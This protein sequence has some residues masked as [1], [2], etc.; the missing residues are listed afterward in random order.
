[1]YGKNIRELN[2]YIRLTVY[3]KKILAFS[4]SGEQGQFWNRGV[5][6]SAS[7]QSFQFIIEGVTSNL[8]YTDIAI[9]DLSFTRGCVVKNE[10]LPVGTTPSPPHNPCNEN[11]FYCGTGD[12]CILKRKQCNWQIDCSTGADEADCGDCDFESGMCSWSDASEG[13]F[14]WQR[15]RAGD[16][17]AYD[18]PT[19]DHTYRNTTGHLVYIEGADGVAGKTAVMSSPQFLNSGGPYC[20]FHLWLYQKQSMNVHFALYY[21]DEETGT[22]SLLYNF[23]TAISNE[24]KWY[25]VIVP[26]AYVLPYFRFSLEATPI[27]DESAEW[28]DSKSVLALDDLE[29][30]NC[31]TDLHGLNC[32]FDD[33][34]FYHGFCMWRQA[35]GDQKDWKK[36]DVFPGDIPDHTTGRTFYIFVDFND[37]LAKKGD[38]AK[39]ESAVQSK[40]FSYDSVFTLWYYF[41]G[42]NVGVFRIIQNN[43]NLGENNTYFELKDSQEDRWML[44]EA[45]LDVND[46]FSMV[47]EAE[48]RDIGPGLLAVD[49]I[50][51]VARPVSPKCDFEVDY[52]QWSPGSL[53][54]TRWERAHGKD[55]LYGNPPVD[56]TTNS[57]MGYYAYLVRTGAS[58]DCGYL[59]SPVYDSVGSQC[60]RF[61]YHMLG[62][63][64]GQLKVLVRGEGSSPDFVPIWTH[65]NNTDEMWSLGMVTIVN[66]HNY[67]VGIEGMTGINSAAIIAIDDIEF[68][69]DSCPD[70]HECDFEYDLCDW[71]NTNNGDDTFDWERSSGYEGGGI[72][73]D[74]TID[75]E[76][77]HYMVA[78]LS[79]KKRGDNA[80]LFG[81]R[82]SSSL[83]CMTFWYSMQYIVNATLSVVLLDVG[84]GVP[85]LELPNSTLDYTWEEVTLTPVIM[86]NTFQ[87]MFEVYVEDDMTSSG[88]NAV[89][90]DDIAFTTN[91]K[92]PTLPPLATTSA[93]TH[94]PSL[95]DCDFEQDDS[96]TCG[97]RQD[98]ED[99]LDWQRHQGQ[100]PVEETGPDTDHTLLTHDGHYIYVSTINQ[101]ERTAKL[102]SPAINT[103]VSGACLSFWYHM[104][105]PSIGTLDIQ[106][107]STTSNISNSVWQRSHEQGTNW[108]QAKIYLDYQMF[109]RYLI[110]ETTP[111]CAGHGDIAVDDIAVDFRACNTGQLC[112]FEEGLCNFEQSLED[113]LDWEL[114]SAESS[115]EE[116]DRSPRKDHSRQTSSGQYLRLSGEGSAIIYSNK[117]NPNFKCAEFWLFS[118]G[119]LECEHVVLRVYRRIGEVT[120]SEAL[121]TVSGVFSHEWNLYRL[122]IDSTSYYSL[123][124][125]GKSYNESEIG[126]DDVR[127]LLTCESMQECNFETDLCIWKYTDTENSSD[128]SLTTGDQLSNPYGPKVDVTFASPYGGFIYF[129]TASEK[130]ANYAVLET[131]ILEPAM[132]CVSFW[133]HVQGQGHHS[134]ALV[135]I[136][137]SGENIKLWGHND[138]IHADWKFTQVTVNVSES[139]TT[140]N[141]LAV[142]DGGK[143]GVIALDQ[144][145]ITPNQCINSTLP[146]CTI[147]CDAGTCIKP[148]QM[149]NFIQDCSQGQDENF[150]G[151]NCTFEHADGDHC[152]WSNMEGDGEFSWVL[153]QGQDPNNTYGPPV[154]HTLLASEGHYVAVAHAVSYDRYVSDPVLLSPVLHNSAAECH[155]TFWYV[156]YEL[157]TDESSNVG[158]L[159]VSYT[160][161]DITTQLLEIYANEREEW[162]YGTVY[163][164]R[165]RSEFTVQ[166]EGKRNAQVTGYVAVDDIRFEDCFLPSPQHEL[167]E[168]F[169]CNN[170]ACVSVFSKCDFVD[171]CGDYSDEDNDLAECD[172]YMG[173]CNFEDGSLCIW[174]VEENGWQLGSPSSQD[175][176]PSRD[177]T[178]N[179]ALGSFIYIESSESQRNS[180]Q[181][182]VTS[183]VI[184]VSSLLCHLRF[185]YYIDG[186]A[187]D[188]LVVSV[189]DTLNGSLNDVKVISGSVGE[190]WERAEVM[191]PYDDVLKVIEFI[192][193]GTTLDYTGGPPSVI[194]MDD[195]S[196]T[197]NCLLSDE[198][199]PTAT[200]PAVSTTENNC[201]NGYHCINGNCILSTEACDFK[202]DCGDN[203]DESVCAECTFEDNQCGWIDLSQGKDHWLR[204]TGLQYGRDGYIMKVVEMT[205]GTTEVAD[206]VSC[207]LGATATSC[208]VSFF[209]YKKGGEDSVLKL[210]ILRDSMELTMWLVTADMGNTWHQQTVG[211]LANDPGWKLRFRVNK[212]VDDGYVMI[213]EVHFH[214]CVPPVPAMCQKGQ[215]SCNNKVCVNESQVCDFSDDCGD[216][217]DE[218]N[219]VCQQ[220]PERCDFETSF[221]HWEQEMD[222][223]LDWMRKTGEM[224]AEG[225]GPDYDHTYGNETGFYMYLESTHGLQGKNAKIS[226]AT[227][228]PSPGNCHFRFWYMMRDHQNA[229]LRIF[230]KETS[231]SVKETSASVKETSVIEERK[232]IILFQSVG[233]SEYL[234]IPE[235]L[236]ITFARYFKIEI[237]AWVGAEVNGDV[238]I[239]DISFSSECRTSACSDDEFQ[240]PSQGCI[241]NTRVCDFRRDCGDSSDEKRCPDRCNFEENACGWEEGDSDGLNWVLAEANDANCGTDQTGPFTDSTGDDEGH[242]LLLHEE[243]DSL[244]EQVGQSYTHWY[245]NSRSEC[246]YAFWYYVP[247]DL[248]T[249][250][251]LRLNSSVDD[252]IILTFFSEKFVTPNIWSF[253][254]IGIGRHKDPFQLSLYTMQYEGHV[255]IF[256]LDETTF[257]HCDFPL[258]S[259]GECASSFYHCPTTQV[260]RAQVF[261]RVWQKY[262]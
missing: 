10:T 120:D 207:S 195:I 26:S 82:V 43:K 215:F 2:V 119:N 250:I 154:D 172:T 189:R 247:P 226:S 23:S 28:E 171:D 32:N 212:V 55:N 71:F 192:M 29:L 114:V 126:I 186:P 135:K 4:R 93:P 41:Y 255:G 24:E 232:D 77:G 25:N 182:R 239:D 187:V 100:T 197:N 205:V 5:V 159:K 53:G 249:D 9:D 113:E 181:G 59:I 156:M 176:I 13:L 83:C 87:I 97:W 94:I 167:C 237:E 179:T 123:G 124:F 160:V 19:V 199:L 138:V 115:G 78:K 63:G 54:S 17:S 106:L 20:Q 258:P 190:W 233:S 8:D 51:M 44:F 238:A 66:M 30:F 72:L 121:L 261:E 57:E 91:C 246:M 185:Y 178:L 245:Q 27:F 84:E 61:W 209:Y 230:V 95:F 143:M 162:M 260:R 240:C 42:E 147:T 116:S 149:C 18:H 218:S 236:P 152:S 227:F 16:V 132:W 98:T 193:T 210:D 243:P 194:A 65:G 253:E 81:S 58:D 90:I 235:N 76:T 184:R 117:I 142:S 37:Q 48:W 241:S 146:A 107:K 40:A 262:S 173:R 206:L 129:D 79:N 131:D 145:K 204:M 202:D 188:K 46:D 217:S 175:I 31:N 222:D 64:V 110:L 183:P 39:L 211:V 150:C 62:E 201:Q 56:H 99:G 208:T 231:A 12:E 122:L 22:R 163:L 102:I 118:N 105:G 7:E 38:K 111:R 104:H 164:G 225:V 101:P 244:P 6:S 169:Y 96:P 140:L 133:F 50:K 155:M 257:Q 35:S 49:D 168:D 108:L 47:L 60:L 34:D 125:E 221:C 75:Y 234:W 254:N 180:T 68:I 109:S 1:M 252:F 73:V 45:K 144:V 136:L 214:D 166:F 259:E 15:V 248:G 3:G 228:L 148:E 191:A 52:C 103:G 153:L 86:S 67:S 213:D 196:F 33:P 89:A 219:E 151:Y 203:S 21:G 220:Y 139:A 200:V 127:P 88:P 170:Q 85:I 177:H 137:Q 198:I 80:R 174:Q 36:N 165:I 134:I 157:P 112:D 74:H 229:S 256:A 70:N 242:F 69:P 223:D 161:S 130:I 11:E 158:T 216:R 251:L 128:W 141:F 14:Q 224:L 92:F